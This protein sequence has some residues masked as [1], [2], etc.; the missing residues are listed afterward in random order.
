MQ[1]DAGQGRRNSGGVGKTV[2]EIFGGKQARK[3]CVEV[4][5]IT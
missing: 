5:I 4:A 2:K 1:V 3:I